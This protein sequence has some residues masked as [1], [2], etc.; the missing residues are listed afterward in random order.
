LQFGGRYCD[1]AAPEPLDSGPLLAAIVPAVPATMIPTV[2]S[3][4]RSRDRGAGRLGAEERIRAITVVL[5]WSSSNALA[6]GLPAR[7]WPATSSFSVS[8]CSSS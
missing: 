2:S 6:R 8:R 3:A 5:I 1:C 7:S 4:T